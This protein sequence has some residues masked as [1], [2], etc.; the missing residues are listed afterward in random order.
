MRCLL[1]SQVN[2]R[3]ARLRLLLLLV[4]LQLL[5]LVL[6]LSSVVLDEILDERGL[7]AVRSSRRQ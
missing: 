4:L 6:L 3:L 5:N 2:A 7:L 1:G